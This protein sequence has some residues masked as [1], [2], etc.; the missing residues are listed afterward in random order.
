MS[1]GTGNTAMERP[2]GHPPPDTQVLGEIAGDRPSTAPLCGD[3]FF[4]IL[5]PWEVSVIV[6]FIV[7]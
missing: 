3:F 7:V 4:L 2:L 5:F 6:V 1:L